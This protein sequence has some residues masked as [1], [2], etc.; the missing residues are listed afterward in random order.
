MAVVG[1]AVQALEG[2]GGD[3]APGRIGGHPGGARWAQQR[4]H[5]IPAVAGRSAQHRRRHRLA[6]AGGD[7]RSAAAGVEALGDGVVIAARS[8]P[9]RPQALGAERLL[10]TR[11]QARVAGQGREGTAGGRRPL[12]VIE[13]AVDGGGPAGVVGVVLHAGVPAGGHG[14]VQ[15]PPH[16]CGGARTGVALAQARARERIHPSTVEDAHGPAHLVVLMVVAQVTGHKGEVEPGAATTGAARPAEP[17]EVDVAH[18]GV[19]RLRSERLVRTPGSGEAGHGTLI[20]ETRRR[21]LVCQLRV[22][23]LREVDERA[24]PGG[25]AGPRGKAGGRP[26]HVWATRH[27]HRCGEAAAGLEADAGLDGGP[28]SRVGL[29]RARGQSARR[30]ERDRRASKERHGPFVP[31][32][33]EPAVRRS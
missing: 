20:L 7:R 11:K 9:R 31:L 27:L 15:A 32:G 3:E 30:G 21:H 22:G 18:G 1:A 19:E 17:V 28:P 5:R 8:V 13:V 4:P 2:P 26:H 14:R 6:T 16:L 23:H 33:G 24:P 10:R 12:R 25:A 29:C